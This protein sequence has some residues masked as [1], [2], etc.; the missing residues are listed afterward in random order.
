M[1]SNNNNDIQLKA[2][3]DTSGLAKDIKELQ[4]SLNKAEIKISAELDTTSAINDIKQL[5]SAYQKAFGE[6]KISAPDLKVTE[7]N[8]ALNQTFDILSKIVTVKNS[9]KAVKDGSDFLKK[10]LGKLNKKESNYKIAWIF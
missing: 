3:L 8:K 9:V 7:Q 6:V 1:P 10:S 2:V 5:S 4:R